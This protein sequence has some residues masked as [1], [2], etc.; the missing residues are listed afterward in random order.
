MLFI[1]F[2][3]ITRD[4]A[5]DFDTGRTERESGQSCIKNIKLT[6][7]LC[8]PRIFAPEFLPVIFRLDKLAPVLEM[9]AIGTESIANR[10]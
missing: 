7:Y 3:K 4:R 9:D 10:R 6:V 5:T 2:L 8:Y 1:Y